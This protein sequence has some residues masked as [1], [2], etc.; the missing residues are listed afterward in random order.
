M[1][2]TPWNKGIKTGLS[3]WRGKKRPTGNLSA[4][5]KGGR[6]KCKKC[7]KEL[8]SRSVTKNLCINCYLKNLK[9]S[10]ETR[11]KMSKSHKL[12]VKAGKNHLWKG[13]ITKTIN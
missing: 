4:N 3:P 10:A 13:G 6:P 5:W 9:H 7:G 11:L 1:K 2:R 8:W 12:L